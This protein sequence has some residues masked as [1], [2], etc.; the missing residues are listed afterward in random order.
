MGR[1]VLH[2]RRLSLTGTAVLDWTVNG[3]SSRR[4]GWPDANRSA[5]APWAPHGI[6][7]TAGEDDWIGIVCRT[8]A[9]WVAV[10]GRLGI[11]DPRFATAADRLR[12]QDELD[13]VM[14]AAT[15]AHERYALARELQALGVPA[16]AVARPHERIDGDPNT[17]GWGLWPE[18]THSKLG[19]VRVD[20]LPVHLSRTDWHIERGG[21]CL[22]EHTEAVLAGARHERR[23]GRP[24]ARRGGRMSEPV[25]EP[26]ALHG[27]RVV[28]LASE[29]GA[30]AGKL[31]AD[32]G[33]DV[34]LV[35]P[36]EGNPTRAYGPFLDD[37]PG[38]D[39][40]LYWWHHHTS[41]RGIV[42]DLTT[43]DGRATLHRLIASADVLLESEPAASLAPL[44]LDGDLHA[45]PPP[46]R[47]LRHHALRPERPASGRARHRP[48]RDR[49]RRRRLDERLG[50]P[51]APAGAAASATT[52]STWAATTA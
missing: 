22:G 15:R 31:L 46:P 11:D 48:H 1:H 8:D 49:R 37:E 9:E 18:T 43:D 21:P 32:M 33:A 10:A 28:E 2:R 29:I 14:A 27:I 7:P 36:P 13:A 38:P 5:H 24:A 26:G 52:A 51:H 16:A 3:R 25:N 30:W 19:R 41:K 17:A 50:R 42:L 35:E 4:D 20:G 47:P 6:Y 34:I 45:T 40:S 12:H 23:R 39:R 44:G